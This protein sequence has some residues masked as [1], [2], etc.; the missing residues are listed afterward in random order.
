[1]D[2]GRVRRV[3]GG[4]HAGS[5]PVSCGIGLHDVAISVGS[6]CAGQCV[7]CL[8]SFG[9][10]DAIVQAR[11][12]RIHFFV[13]CV[14][15]CVRVCVCVCHSSAA[16]KPRQ[17]RCPIDFGSA[18]E[19][20]CRYERRRSKR[21]YECKHTREQCCIRPGCAVESAFSV[22]NTRSRGS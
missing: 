17:R 9:C 10:V 15:V 18:R 6:C 16:L 7:L 14:C 19:H 2:G 5:E 11:S 4:E 13:H 1:M 20:S 21:L 12:S 3:R 22:P 8:L